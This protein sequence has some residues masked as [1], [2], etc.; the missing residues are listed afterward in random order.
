MNTFTTAFCESATYVIS[1]F[2]PGSVGTAGGMYPC[3]GSFGTFG[4]N[5]VSPIFGVYP[6]TYG[7]TGTFG[8]LGSV[9]SPGLVGSVG[10]FGYGSGVGVSTPGTF[11]TQLPNLV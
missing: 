2:V 10:W 4:C 11:G 3:V 7:I 6:G 5:G 1:V 9:G 8:V